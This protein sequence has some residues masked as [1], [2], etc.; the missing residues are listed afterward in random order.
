MRLSRVLGMYGPRDGVSK[1]NLWGAEWCT[2]MRLE[3]KM[4]VG[5]KEKKKW[6]NDNIIRAYRLR[7]HLYL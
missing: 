2:M 7:M 5:M 3:S 6:N 4:T 1:C